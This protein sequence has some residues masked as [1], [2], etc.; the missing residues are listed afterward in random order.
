MAEMNDTSTMIH[1][2][3]NL[4]S[5]VIELETNLI[6]KYDTG[7]INTNDWTNRHLGT[8]ALPKNSDSNVT[9]NLDATFD[10]VIIR[11]LISTD[12]TDAT[13]F[14][15]YLSLQANNQFGIGFFYVD[16]NNVKVQTATL[17]FYAV[18]DD[19]SVFAIDTED[20]YYKIVVYKI[21]L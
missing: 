9:H 20:W 21:N 3:K 19:G 10:Q 14:E 2:I 16:A 1:E 17:G 4:R 15:P 11:V 6:T 18:A 12:G 13:S 8:T 5:R 7:W